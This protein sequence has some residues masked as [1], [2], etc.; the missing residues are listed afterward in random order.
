[1][2]ILKSELHCHNSFSNHHLGDD[3]PPFDCDVS[4]CDQLE[5]IRV[6]GLDTVF[7]TNHNT[8]DGF[9][10]MLEYKN[11][12]EKF[13]KIAIYPA[14]EVTT[15]NGAH[16][17]VYG[18]HEP[19]PFG[20]PLDVILDDV[21]RQGGVS[22]APHPFSLLDALRDD[23]SK[24]D[25]IETFNSNN[26][27]VLSNM[28][29]SQ[30]SVEHNMIQ[31]AGS[32]SHVLSTLGRCVNNVYSENNLDDILYALKHGKI[33]V[34]HTGYAL[35]DETLDHLKYKLNNSR[36][37]VT[38]YIADNYPNAQWFLKLLLWMYDH[39]QDS[40]MWGYIYD[41]CVWAMKRISRK[42]NFQ[43][44][45]P[46]FMKQRNLATMLYNAF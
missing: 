38:Q 1:M 27:D 22:S 10:Q 18:I 7:V 36:D 35:Q 20:T 11:N 4:I 8:L 40:R 37:Y 14:E 24:C 3:E 28:R 34:C 42:I 12:H 9:K 25:M 26:V 15:D 17:L 43:D 44:L 41:L 39:N 23:A 21:K 19:I 6:L 33:E 5:R 13:S 30:F 16:V 46:D 29:A 45:N 31:V 32:D 2:S